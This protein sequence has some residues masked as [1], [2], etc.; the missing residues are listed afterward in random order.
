[1]Y[2]LGSIITA[3][4]LVHRNTINSHTLVVLCLCNIMINLNS[5][6]FYIVV[7]AAYIQREA[8]KNQRSDPFPVKKNNG[9]QTRYTY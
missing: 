3:I 2:S 1:M 6:L 4:T 5:V 8:Y 7:W 9:I